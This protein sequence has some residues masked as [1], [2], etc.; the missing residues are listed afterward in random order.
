MEQLNFNHHKLLSADNKLE[1]LVESSYHI[2][3]MAFYAYGSFMS[4][5][6]KNML[7]NIFKI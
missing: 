2:N 3:R 1:K 6:A 7:K 5:F 4:Y